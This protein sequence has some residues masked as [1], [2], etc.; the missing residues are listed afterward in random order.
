[1]VFFFLLVNEFMFSLLVKE[2]LNVW[3]YDFVYR[4]ILESKERLKMP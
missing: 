1:M 3:S 2:Y 4:V